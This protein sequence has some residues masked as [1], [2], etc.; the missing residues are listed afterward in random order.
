LR[1][2]N[3]K[4]KKFQE[5]VWDLLYGSRY[6]DFKGGLR[7]RWLGP[8]VIEIYHDNGSL[9]IRTID[10]EAIPLLVNGHR[11]EVYKRSLSKK[12]F[13]DGI[14]KTVMVVEQ[15]LAPVSSHH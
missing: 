10:V 5:G 12:E 11:L 8:Y 9:Q 1:D 15:V 6:K 2:K 3:I 13:I 4:D 14:N 7:T